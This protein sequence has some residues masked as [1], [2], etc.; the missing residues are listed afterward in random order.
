M[1]QHPARWKR[2]GSREASN[3][4]SAGCTGCAGAVCG[5]SRLLE[6]ANVPISCSPWAKVQ[7]TPLLHFPSCQN[8]H[9]VRRIVGSTNL[10]LLKTTGC[11][12]GG[13]DGG[14]VI[15]DRAQ[16]GGSDGGGSDCG[17]VGSVFSWGHR[18]LTPRSQRPRSQNLQGS[19]LEGACCCLSCQP[20][21]NEAVGF[22]E[23]IRQSDGQALLAET[24]IAW[25]SGIIVNGC[26]P[27]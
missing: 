4:G 10:V 7:P 24:F 27:C 25:L 11:S 15:C 8:L 3:S 23:S 12:L 17:A 19:R 21:A 20:S 18:Q 2:Q 22:A 6:S 9:I 13:N 16:T 5:A 14:W 1:W 26:R